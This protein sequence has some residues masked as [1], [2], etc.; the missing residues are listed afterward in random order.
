MCK[1][2]FIRPNEIALLPRCSVI[3]SDSQ[4]VVVNGLERHVIHGMEPMRALFS[5]SAATTALINT[6]SVG[7]AVAV[8]VSAKEDFATT[9]IAG[10]VAVLV[11]GSWFIYFLDR[12]D[13]ASRPRPTAHAKRSWAVTSQSDYQ[14]SSLRRPR[15]ARRGR[16][17]ARSA[18]GS[19]SPAD[20]MRLRIGCASG[21]RGCWR[22]R[23]D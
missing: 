5:T 15:S 21:R 8:C 23:R 14:R 6:G 2:L 4:N 9:L 1:T 11:A 17:R 19:V 13:D 10:S 22:W 3:R 12:T 7:V 16:A 18:G 20:I